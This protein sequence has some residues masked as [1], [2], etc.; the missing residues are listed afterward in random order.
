MDDQ[1]AGNINGYQ[2]PVKSPRLARS[3]QQSPFFHWLV[4]PFPIGFLQNSNPNLETSYGMIGMIKR[5]QRS[6]NGMNY[7]NL[8]SQG[9]QESRDLN[10]KMKPQAQNLFGVYIQN[11]IINGPRSSTINI[12]TRLILCHFLECIIYLKDLK[13]ET[14][15]PN[16]K[17][18]SLNF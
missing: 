8:R 14:L 13:A 3:F 11:I 7:V 15:C 9:A 18:L 6:L 12:L 1:E 5:S 4:S 17:S 10:G 16:V 2:R